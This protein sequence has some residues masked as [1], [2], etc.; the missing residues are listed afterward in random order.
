[1]QNNSPPK[2]DEPLLFTF[3]HN[4][5]MT[6]SQVLNTHLPPGWMRTSNRQLRT[7]FS[8]RSYQ[9]IIIYSTTLEHAYPGKEKIPVIPVE[10]WYTFDVV[11]EACIH[12]NIQYDKWQYPTI[13]HM[14]REIGITEV[15]KQFDGIIFICESADSMSHKSSKEL[16]DAIR[17]KEDY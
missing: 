1:M 11:N 7:P 10:Y 6:V 14:A 3:P 17:R 9:K 8:D 12:G 4:T 15:H 13:E 5:Y 16:T 2:L